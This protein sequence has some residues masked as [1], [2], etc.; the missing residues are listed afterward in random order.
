[1]SVRRRA[2][3][4][5]A[6]WALIAALAAPAAAVA[7]IF[8]L[9]GELQAFA[10]AGGRDAVWIGERIAWNETAGRIEHLT[11]WGAG[12]DHA[13]LGI[14][15]FIWYPEGRRGPFRESFPELLAFLAA[16]GV[17]LPEWLTPTTP[18]PWPDREAF[19]A[20]AHDPRLIE[21]R[22]LLA[23][24]TPEQ[25]AFLALRLARALPEL[26]AAAPAEEHRALEDRIARL[27]RAP[28]GELTAAGVYALVDYVNFKGEGTTAG[29]R[30][31]GEGWG[32]LQVLRAMP[33]DATDARAAFAQAAA[34]VLA[35]RVALAPP[36]RRET[37]WL[38]G[39]L[40]RVATYRTA[41]G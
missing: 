9:E 32:L 16:R 26:L 5:V 1:M 11:H 29:E 34:A 39:W 30:Y 25:V 36:E 41:G 4:V 10:R 7:G 24:T 19:R 21:L 12:E 28:D 33:D 20:A 27:L 23:A 8:A 35:R 18:C 3:I 40:R 6:G 31:G 2:R 14:G 17:E 13:S 38:D 22:R 15:H 37:R